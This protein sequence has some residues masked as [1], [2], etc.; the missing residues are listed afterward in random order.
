MTALPWYAPAFA[1]EIN[2]SPIPAALRASIT[3]VTFQDGLN[4]SDRVELQMVNEGLRWLDHPLLALDNTLSLRMGYAPDPLQQVFSGEILAH[5]ASFPSSGTPTLTVVAQDFLQR[6]TIGTKK[7][8][9]GYTVNKEDYP[10]SDTSVI[11]RVSGENNLIPMVGLVGGALSA[12]LG[13]IELAA[14]DDKVARQKLIRKQADES[15]FN[16]LKRLANENGWDMFI[17]H[18]DPLGGRKIRF[19]SPLDRLF[20]DVILAYGRSLIDFTPRI[21]N[22]GLVAAV[23]VNVWIKQI[24]TSL[25]ITLGWDWDRMALTLDVNTGGGSSK[26]SAS[27]ALIEE[28]LTLASA[29]RVLVSRLLPRL[30]ERLAGSGTTIGDLR[31]GA[32]G[33]VKLEGLGM[34]FGG[35]YRITRAKHTIDGS[36]FRTS[37]D[38]RKE[39]W[40][41]SIPLPE[42]GAVPVRMNAAAPATT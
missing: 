26:T 30:N 7:R 35:L 25:S 13:G 9:F 39:I 37:F 38:V 27:I 24:K 23:T 18:S 36:G 5:D 15:D 42:Q 3:S 21:S 20:P 19:Q 22:I 4:G 41:G 28:P 33:V 12:I 32:G 40:F 11:E 17:D 2:G 31:L 34:Q 8:W 16:L 1:V 29:P 10:I 6:T 14:A